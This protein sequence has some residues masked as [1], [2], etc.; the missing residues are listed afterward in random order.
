MR[1]VFLVHIIAISLLNRIIYRT[2][3]RFLMN[4]VVQLPRFFV[5]FQYGTSK[6]NQTICHEEEVY[7]ILQILKFSGS[8]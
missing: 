3:P 6:I 8:L 2:D 4:E 7:L 1:K 5:W